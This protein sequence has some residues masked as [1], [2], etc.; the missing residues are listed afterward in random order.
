[1]YP[2]HHRGKESEFSE[3]G[4]WTER[5]DK[6][7]CWSI[8]ASSSRGA[9]FAPKGKVL[10]KV[11]WSRHMEEDRP[12]C[13]WPPLQGLPTWEEALAY[14]NAS[15]VYVVKRCCCKDKGRQG[16]SCGFPAWCG[17]P[18]VCVWGG[19]Q[20]YNSTTPSCSSL[21]S[22]AISQR[23]PGAVQEENEEDPFLS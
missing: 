22:P 13:H 20:L 18:C 23:C 2:L 10:L 8:S 19:L 11:L 9:N 3:A 16:L 6:Q 5:N 15:A 1:M 4:T 7:S 14:F 17:W 21:L 12:I